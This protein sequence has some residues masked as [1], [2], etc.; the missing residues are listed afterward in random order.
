MNPIAINRGLDFG[1]RRN[2]FTLAQYFALGF[3]LRLHLIKVAMNVLH[4][5]LVQCG[6]QIASSRHELGEALEKIRHLVDPACD[7]EHFDGGT[8]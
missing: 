4:C 1:R 2:Y 7:C 5:Q 3:A 6:V 8:N